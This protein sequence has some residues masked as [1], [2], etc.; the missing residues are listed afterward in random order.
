MKKNLLVLLLSGLFALSG[1]FAQSR[2]IMGKVVGAD[3]GLSLPGV[4]V[5]LQGTQ[6]GVLTDGDGNFVLPAN[7]GQTLEFSF[8]GYKVLQ[9]VIPAGN[10]PLI[11]LKQDS[12]LLSE[13]VVTDGYSTTTK[14]AYTGSAATIK[15]SQNENKPFSTP[16]QALQGEVAGLAVSVNSGQPGANI[17]VRLRGLGSTYLDAN[18]LYVIDG[19]IINSGDLSRSATTA[20]VLAGI[21][22]NDIESI[23]VLKDA[24]ATAI[25]GSRGSNGV[26][27]ITTKRGKNGKTQVR[28]DAE[29][30]VST[31]MALPDAGKPLTGS[32]YA[33]L[34]TEGLKNAGY[35]A[36]TILSAQNAYGL[37]SGQSNNWYDLV[38]KRGSQQQ[39]NVSVN[40]GSDNTKVFSSLGYFHQDATTLNSK[41][42]RISGLVNI[43]HNISKRISISTN[44]NVSNV[45]QNTPY[46]STYYSAPIASA[47]FLRPFQLAYNADGSLNSSTS[48]GTNFPSF[49][50]PLYISQNDVHGL[51]QTRGLIGETL[52]W[53]IWDQ[54]KFTSFTSIDY[55]VLEES[56]YANP[57]M[58]DGADYGG[59]GGDYYT[60]YFNWLTRNQLD[61]RY[62]VKGTQDFYIDA[63][64]GYEAQRSQENYITAEGTGYAASAPTLTTLSLASTPVTAQGT[65]SNYTYN[66]VY[67]RFAAN[68]KNRYVLSGSFRRDGS[69]KFGSD[70]KYGNFWSVGG[71]WNIDEESFFKKQEIVS[72]AKLH[73]SYGTS[74]NANGLGNYASKGSA[75]ISSDYTYAGYSGA[76]YDVI[77]NNS[78]TWE[79]ARKFDVGFDLSFFKN[80]LTISPEYYRNSINGLIQNVAVSQTTGFSNAIENIGA[81]LN[82]GLEL[83]IQ[84]VP[85]KTKDFTWSTNFNVAF[86]RNKMTSVADGTTGVHDTY[87]YLAKGLDYYSY[88]TKLYAGVN[89]ANGDALWYT[90]ATKTKTTTNYSEAKYAVNHQADPKMFGGF[91]NTWNYKGFSLTAEFYYNFGNYVYDPIGRYFSGG[92]YSS[93]NKYQYIYTNRWTTPGQITDVPKFV[94]G[95]I[96]D[97]SGS[98]AAVSSRYWYSGDY[99]RLKNLSFGY[100]FKDVGLL[101][102]LGLSKLNVYVRG[103]NLWTKTYDSRLPFD[104]EVDINGYNS[105]SIPKVKTY[106]L[107]I[108]VG[109]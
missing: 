44:L 2:K 11:K 105:L 6:K 82:K 104:P 73:A 71:S 46:N 99:I 88:Y 106:T 67:S 24:A 43:D 47:Y 57:T 54:L 93:Y 48:G 62:N 50:N 109:L 32:Q 53:N 61:Y 15:G 13:V 69:S 100:D 31:N 79:S 1:A 108:N 28:F 33:E 18:P 74:G 34:Y 8:V 30:G 96:A 55:N 97:N 20:N 27:I 87:Y 64:V 26:I 41:L 45:N 68:Y 65:Y 91:N 23:Q 81:M 89:P 78:L 7:T 36:A 40:G 5:K 101:K 9:V 92:A 103:T 39:Y 90:D 49:Y 60:R 19:M 58:G 75:T 3:D 107:G 21:N 38:T 86:N 63:T 52:K 25:Y 70:V 56:Y 37:N 16:Q 102:R 10:L 76:N 72:A 12:R 17:Q 95:G 29:G 83:T 84:G 98:D 35:S 59:Y 80:R 4:S 66:S 77:G 85:I 22:E 14:K 51:S 94:A 42:T